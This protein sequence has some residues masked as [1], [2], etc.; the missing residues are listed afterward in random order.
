MA[1]FKA[2]TFEEQVKFAIAFISGYKSDAFTFQE[3]LNEEDRI[4][5][6][7][8][9]INCFK[10]KIEATKKSKELLELLDNCRVIPWICVEDEV[11]SMLDFVVDG[12]KV[13]IK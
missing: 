8:V 13:R 12:W 2:S 5:I 7:N 4:M 9:Y 3:I 10:Q 1:T 11:W 6:W